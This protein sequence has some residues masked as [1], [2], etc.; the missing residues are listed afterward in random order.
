MHNLNLVI[1][2][3]K[4]LELKIVAEKGCKIAKIKLLK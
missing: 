1:T 4:E 2:I 3:I